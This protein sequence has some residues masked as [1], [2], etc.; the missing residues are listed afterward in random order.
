MG[1]SK[2]KVKASDKSFE[3]ETQIINRKNNAATK[4]E[5]A[6]AASN[7]RSKSQHVDQKSPIPSDMIDD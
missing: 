2:S 5:P 4:I 3:I 6:K 7:S 1:G